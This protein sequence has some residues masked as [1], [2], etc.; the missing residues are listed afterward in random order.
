MMPIVVIWVWL[1]AYL[2]CAGWVLSACH[3]LNRA[4]YAVAFAIGL[5]ILLVWKHKTSTRFFRP[6]LGH[7][8]RWRF[9]HAFPLG[10]LILAV[11]AGLGGALYVPANYDALAYRTP[12][13]LHWLA[14]N[15]WCWLHTEFARLNT[16]TA[17]FEW[18]TAP[19]ILFTGT[20][21]FVFLLNIICFVLLPGRVFAIL[22]RLGVR[23]RAAWHWMW[24]FPGGYG[25]VLQAGS[26]AND[27]FGGFMAMVAFEFALRAARKKEAGDLWT[28]LPAAGLMTAVKAF[29]LVLLLPWALAAL[30]A[31]PALRRRPVMSLVVILAAVG[32]S[33]VPTAILNLHECGDWTGLKAEQATIGGS[34][35]GYRFLANAINLPLDNLAP[36]IFPFTAQ[37][38]RLVKHAVPPGLSAN[39][40][41]H[42]EAGLSQLRLP[43]M[44]VEESAGL[45]LGLTLLL[46]VLLAKKIRAGQIWTHHFWTPETLVPL[47]AWLSL[48]VFM[49]Q[50]GAAGPARYL[51]PFYVLLA[52][53]ILTGAVAGNFFRSR[54]WQGMGLLVFAV[55][56]LLLVIT[57]PR[58][59][60]PATTI[61][62]HLDAEHSPNRQLQRAWNVYETYGTRGDGFAPVISA[63]PPDAKPLG[64]MAFDEPETGLWRPF[65]S[66]RIAHFRHD[67]PPAILA[68]EG[69]KYALVSERF[70]EEHLKMTSA[71]WL[72]NMNASVVGHFDLKLRAGQPP[73]TW[74]LVHFQ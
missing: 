20:D 68:G 50:T 30:P 34:G 33:L 72:Q 73:T 42:T 60:W 53:P 54:L 40:Q 38:N 52:A 55:A 69:I 62:G 57:P 22:T 5:G 58:P 70:F 35:K 27:M 4:G 45:G 28:S 66:R 41:A 18:V 16:R 26:V 3:A 36:P 44:Q 59:L 24:L 61:L 64:F 11:L 65:G 56:T 12:R 47:G 48:G 63:L 21:R 6:G 29:N 32:A 37:W 74:L 8:L 1:C 15:Q 2:N 46:L 51:L 9:R 71:E 49:T 39:L 67:D 17:G 7:K 14:D 31:L 43:D 10:F 25:Y 23:P 13:V 19:L